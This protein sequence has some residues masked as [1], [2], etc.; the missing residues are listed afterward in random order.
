M[1]KYEVK[2]G[3]FH[4]EFI[5]FVCCYLL[6]FFF[7]RALRIYIFSSFERHGLN[8]KMSLDLKTSLSKIRQIV[9]FRV[10]YDR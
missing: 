5:F 2:I 7:N 4:D 9:H 8:L 6:F 1:T 3:P 10:R